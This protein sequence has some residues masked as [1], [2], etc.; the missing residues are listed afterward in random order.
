MTFLI[1]I[2]LPLA[3]IAL[4]SIGRNPMVLTIASLLSLVGAYSFREV[5]IY[6]GQLTM[7]NF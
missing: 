7:I 4:P 3:M 2:L 5:L 6:A 1:G